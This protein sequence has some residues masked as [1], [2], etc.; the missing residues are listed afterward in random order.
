M[1][2][3]NLQLSKLLSYILH[4]LLIPTLA[5][6]ALML[7]TDLYSIV[8]PLQLKLWLLSLVIIFTFLIPSVSVLI[9]LKLNAIYSVELTHRSER[10]IPL[11]ITSA[12]YMALTFFLKSVNIPPA[13]LYVIYSAT[14]AMLA[15]LLINMV[16]KISLHTLGW[17]AVATTLLSISLRMGIPLTGLICVAVIL[18]GLAGYARLK[19]NAHNQTQV[20]LGYIAGVS[21]VMAI[22]LLV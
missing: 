9:L 17:S 2:A 16:Y 8:L 12:S 4:P 13:F 15:G 10:T 18:S 14:I 3:S 7:R 19:E 5:I 21:I 11:L 1:K 6:L 20:Y 22:A